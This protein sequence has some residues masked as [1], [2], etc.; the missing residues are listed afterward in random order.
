M[1]N[2]DV[3]CLWLSNVMGADALAAQV[4]GFARRLQQIDPIFAEIALSGT[5]FDLDG[6]DNW[7]RQ[8][9][10]WDLTRDQW[11]ELVPNPGR[12]SI[13]CWN[14]RLPGKG[15]CL[16]NIRIN[17]PIRG[18]GVSM[19]SIPLEVNNPQALT[20]VLAALIESFGADQAHVLSAWDMEL[21]PIWARHWRFWVRKGLSLPDDPDNRF[22][23]EQ[24]PYFSAEPWLGGTLYTWPEYEP[25]RYEG[26]A[27][28]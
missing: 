1:T 15:G 10:V 18:N 7:M 22:K 16:I 4:V 6:L 25:W 20:G 3:G 2:V 28:P 26:P 17:G 27:R 12:T 24:G 13:Y 19:N 14:R 11:R 8:P 5:Q 21:H 9:L 23:K